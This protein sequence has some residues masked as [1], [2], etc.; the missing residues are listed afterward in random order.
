MSEVFEWFNLADDNDD[1]PPDGFPEGMDQKDFNDGIREMMAATKR[2]YDGGIEWLDFFTR[3]AHVVSRI[4]NGTFRIAGVDLTTVFTAGRRVKLSGG[5]GTQYGS[6]ASVAFSGGNTNVGFSGDGGAVVPNPTDSAYACS[7]AQLRT[8]ATVNTGTAPGT[9]PLNTG[10]GVL[11]SAAYKDVSVAIGNVALHTSNAVL[12]TGAYGTVGTA[13]GNIPVNVVAAVLGTLAYRAVPVR[14]LTKV[15]ADRTIGG[16]TEASITDFLAVAIPGAN[17][18]KKY[19][20]TLHLPMRNDSGNRQDCTI[21]VRIGT[22]GSIV[23]DAVFYAEALTMAGIGSNTDLSFSIPRL[24]IPAATA[25]LG[26][27][28]DV[29]LTH[30]NAADIIVQGDATTFAFLELYE[31]LD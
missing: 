1:A 15:A 29:T 25:V 14:S 11:G 23:T 8:G 9:I 20:L 27:V 28:V 12:G 5:G 22:N 21:R 17:G 10:S 18:A 16:T 3:D 4:D 19:A 7:I 6:V 13:I 2:F 24:E 30:S 26:S 31:I